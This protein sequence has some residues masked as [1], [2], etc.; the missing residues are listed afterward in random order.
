MSLELRVDAREVLVSCKHTNAAPFA[1]A[2]TLAVACV[3]SS[4]LGMN[5]AP[6]QIPQPGVPPR[7][8]RAPT[9]ALAQPLDGGTVPVDKPVVVLR[10]VAG[11][12]DDA[13]DARSFVIVIDGVD[14]S[15]A[16]QLDPASGTAWGPLGLSTGSVTP[17]VVS[18]TSVSL[19]LHRGT[20]RICSLRGACTTAAF[21]VSVAPPISATTTPAATAP[22]A[23]RSLG[24]AIASGLLQAIRALVSP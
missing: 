15:A 6:G 18:Q 3:A 1:R 11:E 8:Y 16:F 12:P 24:S 10:F 19:G 22:P 17:T 7:P 20:A 21:S 2:L 5:S 14:R 9:L 23:K 4:G 13:I